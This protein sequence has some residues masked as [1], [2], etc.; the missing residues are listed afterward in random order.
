MLLYTFLISHFSEKARWGLDLAG[1]AYEEKRLLPAAHVPVI[2]RRAKRTSVPVL[3]DEGTFIQGSSAILDHIEGRHGKTMLAVPP[4]QKDEARELE[5]RADRV[6]GLGVQRIF[7]ATL[8]D[9][10]GAIVEL[11]TQNG[12]WWG[13]TFYGLTMWLVKRGVARQY[14]TR[15]GPRRR[16]EGR[17]ATHLRPSS[18]RGS[19]DI[20]ISSAIR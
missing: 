7:Y 18:T 14:D 8:L 16:S 13:R 3:E 15:P 1:L 19:T 6:F 9:H 5:K 17:V 2:K 12:P 11:W 4:E 10:P 20:R